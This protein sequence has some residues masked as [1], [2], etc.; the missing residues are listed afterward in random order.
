MS[1]ICKYY[2]AHTK[3][4]ET[5][6][7]GINPTTHKS[8]E[9]VLRAVSDGSPENK[10]FYAWTPY[11]ELK[12]ETQDAA[13]VELVKKSSQFYLHIEPQEEDVPLPPDTLLYEVSKIGNR[14][15]TT[16]KK[17]DVEM[18]CRD[19]RAHG[20]WNMGTVNGEAAKSFLGMGLFTVRLVPA[21]Q[22]SSS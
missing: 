1:V 17:Y 9:L 2:L 19:N 15:D 14:T 8:F 6:H 18:Q 5:E 22:K 21:D 11:G 10:L 16:S 12:I 13:L 7:T 4:T 3:T 20:T